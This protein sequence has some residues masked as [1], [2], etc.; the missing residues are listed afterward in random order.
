MKRRDFAATLMAVL[1]AGSIFAGCGSADKNVNHNVETTQNIQNAKDVQLTTQDV[2]DNETKATNAKDEKETESTIQELETKTQEVDTEVITADSEVSGTQNDSD[3]Q[4][5]GDQENIAAEDNEWNNGNTEDSNYEGKNTQESVENNNQ[6]NN[7]NNAP[8]ESQAP[9]SGGNVN[10]KDDNSLLASAKVNTVTYSAYAGEV[11]R[12]V[13][14]ERDKVGA[15]HLVLDGALCDAANMRAI[16]M[17]YSGNFSH[18]R[19]DGRDCFTVFS[20]CKI[21]FYTCGENI[22]AGY[23]TPAAVVDGWMNSTGHKAN[24]LNTAFTKMGLGY[25]TGGGGEYRHYWA[26]EFAG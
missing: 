22:A 23:P 10:I 6:N 12:L 18:T 15:A 25:S 5:T 24:I 1:M 2:A 4:E 20:F 13:N 3:I 8:G 9:A 7:G 21:S 26:Q 16:E 11:L 19:P 17:D 14:I